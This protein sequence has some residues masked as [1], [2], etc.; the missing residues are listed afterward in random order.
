MD[1]EL[2]KVAE[3]A[4]SMKP[5]F[6]YGFKDIQ[7]EAQHV[8]ETGYFKRVTPVPEDTR[9]GVKITLKVCSAL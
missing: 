2:K 1:G 8:F 9:D 3:Q 5:N 6:T 4:L 7:A